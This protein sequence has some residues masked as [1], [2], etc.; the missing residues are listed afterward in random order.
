MP[1]VVHNITLMVFTSLAPAGTLAAIVLGIVL[2]CS[3][4]PE[5]RKRLNFF[6]ILPLFIVMVGLV[7]SATH[8]GNPANALY[9]FRGV[10]RSPLSTEVFCAVLFLFIGGMYWL[11]HFFQ[12]QSMLIDR[13]WLTTLIV[14]SVALLIS[15]AMSYS[16]KTIQSWDNAFVPMGL[17]ANSLASGSM[18]SVLVLA[19]SDK[20]NTK[21]KT[22]IILLTISLIGAFCTIVISLLQAL[23]LTKLQTAVSLGSELAVW[24]YVGLM[25]FGIC[26]SISFILAPLKPMALVK[27]LSYRIRLSLSCLILFV[28]IFALRMAFY[29]IHFTVGL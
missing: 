5:V 14:S 4:A 25:V 12:K 26:A 9:L 2:L 24:I 21:N 11:K 17:I 18:L 1:K 13:I 29:A 28:G 20:E 8:L 27:R 15:M 19:F 23:N 7:T 3:L 10:G 16:V 6:L 22:R